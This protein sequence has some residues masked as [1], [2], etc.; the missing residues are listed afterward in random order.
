MSDV[1]EEEIAVGV[2]GFFDKLTEVTG[3]LSNKLI[4]VAPAVADALLNLVQFKGVFEIATSLIVIITMVTVVK[5][6]NARLFEYGQKYSRH[7]DGFSYVPWVG[8]I[9]ISS[10]VSVLMFFNLV[11][12]YNWLS[13][14]Y[15]EGALALKALEAANI[16][17]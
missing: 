5:I 9:F 3:T 14:I 13:A 11:D 10:F 1:I 17:L 2:D 15:P 12:V 7:S 4:D 16:K 8:M 6:N